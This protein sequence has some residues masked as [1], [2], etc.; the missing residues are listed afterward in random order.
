MIIN[1]NIIFNSR[2]LGQNSCYTTRVCMGGQHFSTGVHI[3]LKYKRWGVQIFRNI[4]TG[5]NKK[6][7]G[8]KFVVTGRNEK[9]SEHKHLWYVI[10]T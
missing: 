10:L 7:G 1:N 9:C 8:S 3:F 2:T 6:G 5:G 4:W